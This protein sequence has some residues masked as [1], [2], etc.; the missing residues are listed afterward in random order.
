M[1]ALDRP[2]VAGR[3][4]TPG[5]RAKRP[6]TPD[7]V[8]YAPRASDATAKTAI[9]GAA[10]KAIRFIRTPLG[11]YG[12]T[13]TLME[14]GWRWAV[15][16]FWIASSGKRWVSSGSALTAPSFNRRIASGNSSR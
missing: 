10:R 4:V 16:A 11:G 12:I 3:G 7:D 1:E 8:G 5:P 6:I 13:A 14:S 15:K 2:G 9:S